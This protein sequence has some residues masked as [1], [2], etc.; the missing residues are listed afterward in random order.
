MIGRVPSAN[1]PVSGEAQKSYILV[2]LLQITARPDARLTAAAIRRG[3]RSPFLVARVLG[4]AT[5]GLALVLDGLNLTLLLTGA[6]L[7]VGVPMFL[8]NAGL[9]QAMQD[10][11]LTTYEISDSGVASASMG[12]R[13]A[14]AWSSFRYVEQMAGQIVFGRSRTRIM[15]VPTAGLTPAQIEQVLG[16]AAGHGVRVRRA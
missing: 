7:A 11:E 9:R 4:W 8:T 13:H 15:P 3:L 16:T 1:R 10:D 12:S 2:V 5:I 14:Y 6:L